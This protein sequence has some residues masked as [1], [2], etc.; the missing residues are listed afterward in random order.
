LISPVGVTL[1][2]VKIKVMK[3]PLDE[4]AMKVAF[5][6]GLIIVL[7]CLCY[8]IVTSNGIEAAQH[9]INDRSNTVYSLQHPEIV[10][11]NENG[12]VVKRYHDYTTPYGSTIYEIGKTKT[13]VTNRGKFGTTTDVSV[14]E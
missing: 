7:I 11:T 12:E 6:V 14:E 13:A 3:I 5:G 9:V 1:V 10:G 4:V 2:G 8:G